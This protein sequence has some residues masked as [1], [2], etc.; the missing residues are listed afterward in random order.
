MGPQAFGS[1]T[2]LDGGSCALMSALW[3]VGIKENYGAMTLVQRA[4]PQLETSK[5][6][7]PVF[8]DC[9][10]NLKEMQLGVAIVHLNDTHRWSREKIA[11][12]IDEFVIT[13]KTKVEKK[14]E[15]ELCQLSS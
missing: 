6:S 2:D 14:I 5:T 9:H 3:G 11:G 12:W 1:F 8:G 10:T 4:F 7:C 15:N 13:D